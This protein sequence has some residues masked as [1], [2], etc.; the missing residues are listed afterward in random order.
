MLSL[1]WY[2]VALI[3]TAASACVLA[4]HVPR[5]V[6]WLCLGA[7]SYISSA[8]WHNAG[9]PYGAFYGAATNLAIC[10]ALWIYADQRWEMRLWNCFHLML[11]VDILYLAGFIKDHLIFAEALELIN[12]VAMLFIAGTGIV[13]RAD[14]IRS[15]PHRGRW[16]DSFHRRLW[17]PR[18][19][20]SRPWWQKAR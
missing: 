5:A 10:Y 17:T 6:L 14:G 15:G 12:F 4:W 20:A 3:A 9:L 18:S 11:V 1:P 7:L 13:E 8:W 2:H 16:I 19:M